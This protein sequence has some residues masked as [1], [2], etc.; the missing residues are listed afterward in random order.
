MQN[1]GT[2][3]TE[4]HFWLVSV[5][6]HTLHLEEGCLTK[7]ALKLSVHCMYTVLCFPNQRSSPTARILL[8]RSS[9]LERTPVLTLFRLTLSINRCQPKTLG[10]GPAKYDLRA[11]SNTQGCT[12]SDPRMRSESILPDD[13]WARDAQPFEC[14]LQ[15]PL[16]NAAGP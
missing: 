5:H 7:T 3:I 11:D 1:P 13:R 14:C 9:I 15:A 8:G 10:I 12:C 6:Q 2:S 16:V 4:S